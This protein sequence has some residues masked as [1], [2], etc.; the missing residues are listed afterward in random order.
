MLG[1]ISDYRR[2]GASGACHLEPTVADG[3]S[4][5]I[6][7]GVAVL[8][9]QRLRDIGIDRAGLDVAVGIGGAAVG[10]E[11]GV[12]A[13]VVRVG[14]KL[15]EDRLARYPDIAGVE[16]QR[17]RRACRRCAVIEMPP[18]SVFTSMA[19][20]VMVRLSPAATL[21]KFICPSNRTSPPVV[22]LM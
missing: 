13:A 17:P 2:R 4:G 8:Y 12:A 6:V 7:G 16:R 1:A 14:A 18:V 20:A 19:L 21:M 11:S 10:A 5:G 15:V 9:E 22:T 3:H